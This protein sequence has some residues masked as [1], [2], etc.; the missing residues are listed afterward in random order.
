MDIPELTY[1]EMVTLTKA[2]A[3]KHGIVWEEEQAEV[4]L[5]V[6]SIIV[7]NVKEMVDKS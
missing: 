6:Q 5:A 3:Y 1:D 2:I 4:A 7:K